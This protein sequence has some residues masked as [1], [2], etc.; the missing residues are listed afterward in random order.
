MP[1]IKHYHRASLAVS[2]NQA[3]DPSRIAFLDSAV[4]NASKYWT[5]KHA[6]CWDLYV[7]G[8]HPDFQSRGIGKMLV[9]WGM[10]RA[11]QE[12]ASASVQCGEKNRGFYARCGLDELLSEGNGGIALFRSPKRRDGEV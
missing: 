10:E 9:E 3:A 7:C 5:G 4:S 2:P 12:C 11:D 1:A 8:V 6:E